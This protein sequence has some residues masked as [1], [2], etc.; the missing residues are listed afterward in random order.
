MARAPS[1]K[2]AETDLCH[3]IGQYLTAQGY[4][5]RSEVNHCDITAV[6]G[7]EL[8]IIELKRSVNVTLLIQAT[9]RQHVTDS[10]YVALPRPRL[11]RAW[12][13]IRHLLRRL[14]LGLIWVSLDGGGPAVEIVFHPVPFRRRK[15]AQ[16]RRAVL[17]EIAG[18]PDD[19]NQG[20]S[21]RRKIVTAY[22]ENVIHIAC[23]LERHGPLSP[24]ELRAM[25]TGAKTTSIL[26]SDFY[27]WFERV[28]AGIYALRPQGQ[29]ELARYPAVAQRYR[30]L[31]QREPLS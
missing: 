15:R 4:T 21:T 24:R 14:E 23:C 11:S 29:K 17:T 5:V 27:G 30:C 9:R 22:R 31:A 25:G 1:K 8:I 13:G 28:A 18:R 20:G 7:D 2:S 26:C 16:A 3:P 19:L 6:K 12:K 10:V